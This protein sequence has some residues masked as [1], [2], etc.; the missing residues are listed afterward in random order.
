MYKL[1]HQEWIHLF[2][3]INLVNSEI[4]PNT[5]GNRVISAV[6]EIIS[7]EMV[8]FDSFTPDEVSVAW[9]N[10][11]N[12]ISNQ[13][14]EA[15]LEFAD[16]HPFVEPLLVKKLPEATRVT[17]LITRKE[18][19]STGLF[20]EFYRRMR[21][22]DTM[23]VSLPISQ[24]MTMTNS[25]YRSGRNFSDAECLML[26]LLST[27]L[28]SA[29]INTKLFERIQKSEQFLQN[30]LVNKS[31]GIIALNEQKE[32]V[33]ATEFARNML[34]KYFDDSKR[35]SKY[36]PQKLSC[37]LINKID[38]LATDSFQ[39]SAEVYFLSKEN[40]QLTIRY[41]FNTQ[42]NETSLLVEE[43]LWI[44]PKL[45]EK[46]SLTKRET[47]ILF[48]ISQGKADKEIAILCNISS[49]TVQKHIENIYVKIGVETRTAA[50]LK[51]LEI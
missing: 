40:D 35:N 19:N 49:R 31:C 36:L 45:L 41:M 22:T 23:G 6:K 51:V 48:W 2:T 38:S 17:D 13:D 34:E 37:W 3:A 21:I 20:N 30:G 5:L 47:E 18:F 25:I 33:Y 8:A 11:V 10:P 15:F 28:R 50:M 9:F 7:C 46:F 29:I 26:T 24:E 42:T 43:K 32:I 14:F 44:K 16:E 12:A 1:R 27:H 39:K 4:N